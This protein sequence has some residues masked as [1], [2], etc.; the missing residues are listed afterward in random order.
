MPTF[1]ASSP[2]R[3]RRCPGAILTALAAAVRRHHHHPK[4]AAVAVVIGLATASGVQ[5]V[6]AVAHEEPVPD[7][8]NNRRT[9]PLVVELP[10][11][12]LEFI[13]DL[14]IAPV[15]ATAAA[16][17]SLV[18]RPGSPLDRWPSTGPIT[19]TYGEHRGSH[20]HS[21]IDIDGDTGDTI[22]TA[23]PGHVIA[24]GYLPDYRGYGLVVL[25][26]HGAIQT[27][28]THLS[29]IL[30]E[31]GKPVASGTTVGAMGTT[32][33]TTGSHLH[34]EVRQGDTP[35]DPMAYLPPR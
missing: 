17:P 15:Q 32:G 5:P 21:G 2:A 14:S 31:A 25:V 8:R 13:E 23:G 10:G 6:V 27:L 34:F 16:A 35:V 4:L 30:V 18:A 28:Y 11:W 33:N 22:I 7:L 29:A 3:H 20:R 12:D 9:V 26:D 1:P 24:T 19:G